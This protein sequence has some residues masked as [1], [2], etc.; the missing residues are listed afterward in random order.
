MISSKWNFFPS[1]ISAPATP[2]KKTHRDDN[3]CQRLPANTKV[4]M[5][6]K[7]VRLD[8]LLMGII[9]HSGVIVSRCDD[10]G[11]YVMDGS[12]MLV[13]NNGTWIG[14]N[15]ECKRINKYQGMLSAMH[16]SPQLL[17]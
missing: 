2:S 6:Y 12:Q 4:V 1:V 14:K 17:S 10:V 3:P 11:E 15:P 7:G 9:P 8:Y 13:C 5:S 16:C